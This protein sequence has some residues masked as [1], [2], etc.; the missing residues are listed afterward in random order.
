MTFFFFEN[1]EQRILASKNLACKT[2]PLNECASLTG[3]RVVVEDLAT[4]WLKAVPCKNTT[5]QETMKRLPKFLESK[6]RPKVSYAE[7]SQDFCTACED[8]QWNRCT[9]TPHRSE[10]H[11]TAEWT[12][13]SVK[14]EGTFSIPL[15]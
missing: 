15:Q 12:V 13:R 7:N 1:Y 10:S 11:G 2:S 3:T 6:A 9:S 8:L 5:S 14:K 4:H